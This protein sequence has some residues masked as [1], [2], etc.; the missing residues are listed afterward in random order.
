MKHTGLGYRDI[1]VH[2]RPGSADGGSGFRQ[3]LALAKAHDARVTA[4][5][6]ESET[7]PLLIDGVPVP[8]PASQPADD[9][10]AV[11]GTIAML[12]R[13]GKAASVDV[14]MVT[15]RSFA[16][17]IGENFADYARVKDIALLSVPKREEMG[18]RF[19]VEGALFSSG[20]PI[21]LTP[22]GQPANAFGRVVVGWDATPAAV[23]AIHGAL[24]ILVNAEAVTLVRV[25]DDKQFRSGQSGVEMVHHLARRGIK[26]DYE[27]VER[28]PDSVAGAFAKVARE[29]EA[30]LVVMGAY[31]HSRLRDLFLG[32]ATT[33]VLAGALPVAALL[34]A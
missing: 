8:I 1:L 34:A 27:D 20:R 31:A 11:A 3:A 25:S 14:E 9:A 33:D 5:V 12:A 30:T 6:V 28:G 24:P 10:E 29:R 19:M 2:V 21:I 4:F 13:M 18:R 16:Y 26:V 23:R 7:T 17:G 22:E 15:A 32:S